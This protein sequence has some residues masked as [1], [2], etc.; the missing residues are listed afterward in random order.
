MQSSLPSDVALEMNDVLSIPPATIECDNLKEN[1]LERTMLFERKRL[2]QFIY[3]EGFSDRRLTQL[4][5]HVQTLLGDRAA[6]FGQ[7]LMRELFLH[8]LPASVQVT[9]SLSPLVVHAD[10]I[11]KVAEQSLAAQA[12]ASAACPPLFVL[13]IFQAFLYSPH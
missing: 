1:V 7:Q 5:R 10:K 9:L 8:R 11:M 13:W 3:D 4:L 6:T 2:Q 12:V